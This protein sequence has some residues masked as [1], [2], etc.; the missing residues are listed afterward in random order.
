MLTEV[1]IQLSKSFKEIVNDRNMG[2]S[3]TCGLCHSQNRDFHICLHVRLQQVL[4]EEAQES[5][6]STPSLLPYNNRDE[7]LQSELEHRMA[8]GCGGHCMTSLRSR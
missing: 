8:A 1:I 5:R 2:A 7:Y 3:T 4:D 6:Y